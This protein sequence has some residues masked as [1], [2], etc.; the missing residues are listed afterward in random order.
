MNDAAR[1]Q[2]I[3]TLYD[4]YK[5]KGFITEDEAL[6]LFAA[7]NVSLPQIDSITAHLLALGVIIQDDNGVEDLYVDR[8]KI[9]YDKFFDEV[10]EDT[11]ELVLFTEYIRG[12]VPPQP[13]EWQKL[14]PQAQNGNKFAK[15]RMIEM[16]MRL[17][18]RTAWYYSHKYHFSFYI[19]IVSSCPNPSKKL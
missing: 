13:R 18:L 4:C 8:S 16:Y 9:D 12:I 6:S 11:P 14:I 1:N 19:K 10:N 17:I 3:T 7:N 5:A 2:I 15:T